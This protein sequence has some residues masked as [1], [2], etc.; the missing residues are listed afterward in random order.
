[1]EGAGWDYITSILRQA[2]SK[3]PCYGRFEPSEKTGT[4]KKLGE[5][6]TTAETHAPHLSALLARLVHPPDRLQPNAQFANHQSF[7]VV[8]A[9][10]S[11]EVHRKSSHAL[12]MIIAMFLK[13]GGAQRQAVEVKQ[14]LRLPVSYPTLREQLEM[15]TVIS[16]TKSI[17][18]VSF[19]QQLQLMKNS[20][21]LKESGLLISK[22]RYGPVE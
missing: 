18:L 22:Q 10:L 11:H 7:V 14:G 15:A 20:N 3:T 12:E 2:L 21:T 8:T 9:L 6:A 1:M 4:M 13:A 17:R 16:K 5:F 19:L